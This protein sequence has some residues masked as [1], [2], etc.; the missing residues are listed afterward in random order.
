MTRIDK[1]PPCNALCRKCIRSCKQP[2]EAL[3][4]DCPRFQP[5]P[6]KVAEHRFDQLDLFGGGKKRTKD[7]PEAPNKGAKAIVGE[8][9]EGTDKD[10]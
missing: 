10:G 9:A 3:L 8:K 7:K 4:L 2:G 5:R 1:K 6:F